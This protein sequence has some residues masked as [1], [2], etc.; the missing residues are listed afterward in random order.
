MK[1]RNAWA[2]IVA[3]SFMTVGVVALSPGSASALP[4][5]CE[6]RWGS[7]STQAW[8]RCN[9]GTGQYRVKVLCDATWPTSN[10]WR[11]GTWYAVGSGLPSYVT[12]PNGDGA[13]EK[14]Y[15]RRGFG[16]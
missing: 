7:H 8:A 13:L 16:R 3:A 9:A 10:Y 5:D 14:Y 4:T 1:I 11:Y 12:C 2:G 15:E 6:A